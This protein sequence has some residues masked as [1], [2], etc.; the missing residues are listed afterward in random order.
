MSRLGWSAQTDAFADIFVDLPISSA[1][2]IYVFLPLLVFEAGIATDVRRM[3]EDAAPI[4]L[5][6]IVA[7]LIT[8]AVIGLALW[9]LAGVPLVV[10]L[11]LGAVVSTTDPAAVIAIFRDIGAPARLTRLVEGEALLNDAAAI[12]LFAVLL[13][14]IA[15]AREPDI[16]SGLSEF[17]LSFIGGGVL[18]TPRRAR[19]AMDHSLAARRSARRGHADPGARLWRLHCRRTPLSRLGR[20]S[21]CW[22]PGSPSARSAVPGSPRTTGRSWPI[23]GIRSRFGRALWSLFSP[24]SSSR[25]FSAMSEPMICCCCSCLIAAAFAARALVLFVLMPLLEFFRLTQPISSAYKLAIIWGGLRGALTLVLALAATENQALGPEMQ[26]FIAVLATGFVLFTLFVNGTTLRL[27]IALLGLDRLSPRNQVLRDRVLAVAYAEVS[28]SVRQMAQYHALAQTAVEQVVEPYQAWIAAANARDEA[29]RLTERDRLADRSCRTGE[30]GARACPRNPRRPDRFAGN[31]TSIVAECRCPRRR[32]TGRRPPR[33]SESCRSGALVSRR[34]PCCLFPLPASR[35]SAFLA[36]AS[37]GPCRAAVGHSA[38]GRQAR[39]LQRRAVTLGFR[40]A[41]HR[42]HRRNHRAPS[43]RAGDAFDALRRQ[44]PD[45]VAALEARFL[46]Q[47]ALRQEM[48]RYQA[49][50]EEGLIPQELYDDL[51]RGVAGTRIAEPRPRFEIGLDTRRLI[52]RLD[53]LSGLDEAQLDRVAKLLRP[54]FTVPNERIIRRGDRGDAVFF[55][56]SGAVE[57]RLPAHRGAARQRRVLWRNGA[58]LGAAATGRC[59]GSD[60]LPAARAAKS[61]FRA[62]PGGKSGGEND[63]KS[64]RG[65]AALDEPGRERSDTR[66]RLSLA[67][68]RIVFGIATVAVPSAM[69]E[70]G[71]ISVRQR[72]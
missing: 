20:S 8:T 25:A 24:R 23:S 60:L 46:R 55:I 38:A 32:R 71:S 68:T 22:D 34:L 18:G 58:A 50:F 69:P 31:R 40:G 49:L 12:A 47:S 7:T 70:I 1:T 66:G 19:V 16:G 61:R 56:A 30:P 13:G 62:L 42:D 17:F 64:D 21:P 28:D 63:D 4:L 29:E 59:G 57:V 27:V 15:T 14:M 11:L 44:Y 36:E 33:I 72:V 5:L 39:R 52:E 9:P 37:G 53:L 26:R 51:K 54:R 35:D 3:L 10:C 48:G 43:G 45:Y 41:P 67:F 6:A 65:G 2:F